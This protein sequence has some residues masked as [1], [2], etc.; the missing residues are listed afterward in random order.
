MTEKELW[1]WYAILIEQKNGVT[2][3]SFKNTEQIEHLYKSD[4]ERLTKI[5]GYTEKEAKLIE[6]SKDKAAIDKFIYIMKEKD[7]K[8]VTLEDDKYPLR[9]RYYSD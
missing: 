5:Y 4:I 2:N 8:L 3:N 9:L 7:I 6:K 1:L